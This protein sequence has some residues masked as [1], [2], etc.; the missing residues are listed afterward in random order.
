M[1]KLV[2]VYAARDLQHAYLLKA[3]LED[4]GIEARIGNEN[5]QGGVGELPAGLATAPRIVV[6]R[7]DAQRATEVLKKL[8]DAAKRSAD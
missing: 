6:F 8:E 2:E 3:A 4:A 7:S 1:D 5:L